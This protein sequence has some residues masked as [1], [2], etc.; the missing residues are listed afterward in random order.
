MAACRRQ[1]TV[2]GSVRATRRTHSGSQLAQ[3]AIGCM[4]CRSLKPA[5]PKHGSEPARNHPNWASPHR[6][7][8][9]PPQT[10]IHARWWALGLLRG[11]HQGTAAIPNCSL[12]QG[13][14][15]QRLLGRHA[16][17]CTPEGSQGLGTSC[18]ASFGCRGHEASLNISAFFP[19]V[20]DQL[21]QSAGPKVKTT[22]CWRG[23]KLA[24]GTNPRGDWAAPQQAHHELRSGTPSATTSYAVLLACGAHRSGSYA[25]PRQRAT[26]LPLS[27][28]QSKGSLGRRAGGRGGTLRQRQSQ[29]A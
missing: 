18:D 2:H 19:T 5:A 24:K 20:L 15:C 8:P 12:Q 17:D 9:A 11:S 25:T 29:R 7:P 14:K 28:M 1:K 10:L 13:L 21:Q 6:R 27:T 23:R 3:P 22:M 26:T 16:A 4:E